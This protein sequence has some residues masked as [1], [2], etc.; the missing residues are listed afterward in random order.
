MLTPKKGSVSVP[1]R[2]HR[3]AVKEII[4]V[5][6][7][8]RAEQQRGRRGVVGG[9]G[10]RPDTG[11]EDVDV[12]LDPLIGVV[13]RVVDEASPVV[14]LAV[15]PVAGQPI[16]QPR[17][18][19]QHEPLHQEQIQHDARDV[20]GGQDGENRMENQKPSLPEFFTALSPLPRPAAIDLEAGQHVVALVAEQH[21]EAHARDHRSNSTASQIQT[22][23]L[24]GPVK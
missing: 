23:T 13:D 16:G 10:Q 22:L 3:I 5:I 8:D 7:D 4:D 9:V 14:G 20:D 24:S 19:P 18:P 17:A 1:D 2:F 6:E 12:G 11:G 15:Q 21:V